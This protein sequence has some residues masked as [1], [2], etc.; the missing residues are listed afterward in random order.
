MRQAKIKT[1]HPTALLV[2]LAV[3]IVVTGLLALV[4]A[5]P[6]ASAAS[7]SFEPAPSSP[8]AVGS[9]PT[10][11]TNADFDGDGKMDLAA[12]NSDSNTV[13]VRLGTGDGTFQDKPDVTVGSG[14]TSVISA[15][16]NEDGKADLA[17]SNQFSGSVSVLRGNGD[18]TFQAKQDFAV[19][20]APTSAISADFNGDSHADLAVANLLFQ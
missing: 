6:A 17:T 8:F 12:Q 13:S 3:G 14:P 1:H 20:S 11:V 19:G 16:F 15:D 4:S 10:T 9:A 18:G 2:L 5:K 7:R